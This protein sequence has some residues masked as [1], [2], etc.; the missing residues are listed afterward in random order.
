MGTLAVPISF[1]AAAA[2]SAA[3]FPR[4]STN[5]PSKRISLTHS[6]WRQLQIDKGRV[7]RN[8]AGSNCC[9][10]KLQVLGSRLVQSA[11]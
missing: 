2:I 7:H 11:S 3:F 6:C 1:F 8:A 4:I 9:A 5:S 10:R